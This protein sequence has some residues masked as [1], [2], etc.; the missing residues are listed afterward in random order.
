ATRH[1]P[2]FPSLSNNVFGCIGQE[3]RQHVG[4][5]RTIARSEPY[6]ASRSRSTASDQVGLLI[7]NLDWSRDVGILYNLVSHGELPQ[8]DGQDDNEYEYGEDVCNA[9]GQLLEDHYKGTHLGNHTIEGKIVRDFENLLDA[10]KQSLYPDNKKSETLLAFVI[11]MLQVK[12][13][14]GWSN[15]SFNDFLTK[16]RR[17]YPEG[18]VIPQS[19]NEC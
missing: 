1:L 4:A 18:H 2:H 11:E 3:Q 13:K 12:V 17:F 7:L 19:I 16:M 5:T 9:Y 8:S 10:A 15:H 6:P 14:S